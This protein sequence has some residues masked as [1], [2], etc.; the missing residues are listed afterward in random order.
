MIK[1]FFCNRFSFIKIF[2]LLISIGYI[3]SFSTKEN[4]NQWIRINQLGYTPDG[5]KVAVWCSKDYSPINTFVLIDS[6]TCKTVFAQNAGKSFGAYG[7]FTNSYR[8]NFSSFNKPG[9]YY[10]KAGEA[11]SPFFKIDRDAYKGAA[12]FCLFYMRQ[13]RSGF[14]PFLEDSCHTH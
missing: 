1:N 9:K 2:L 13:Q 3:F 10:L 14:N 5:I 6:A 7:P 11:V 4:S 12:D 8:L